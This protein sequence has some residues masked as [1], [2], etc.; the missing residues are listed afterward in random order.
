MFPHFKMLKIDF[1]FV[2]FLLYF[3]Y[4]FHFMISGFNI[5]QK[6]KRSKEKKKDISLMIHRTFWEEN[7]FRVYFLI[8][9]LPHDLKCNII[10]FLLFKCKTRRLFLHTQKWSKYRQCLLLCTIYH[11]VYIVL[12]RELRR[13]GT[14]Q[15]CPHR[16]LW[17]TEIDT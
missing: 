16:Y 2:L 11:Y 15:Q 1:F 17:Q 13:I 6:K 7:G 3:L 8:Y 14:N 10:L 5:K 12:K 4:K 9:D